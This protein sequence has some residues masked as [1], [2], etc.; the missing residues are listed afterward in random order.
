M[1][2]PKAEKWEE[3]EEIRESLKTR[4]T[5]M[6][7]IFCKP[8]ERPEFK[9]VVE[10][11]KWYKKRNYI[12]EKVVGNWVDNTI[13]ILE[14]LLHQQRQQILKEVNSINQTA[15]ERGLFK[16]VLIFFGI[17]FFESL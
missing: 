6:Y 10:A 3:I 11:E 12:A 13:S 16:S 5:E 8:E 7:C 14:N 9:T 15:K 17:I 2:Q 1:K 4:I